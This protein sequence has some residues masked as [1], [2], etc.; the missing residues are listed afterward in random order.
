MNTDLIDPAQDAPQ[1]SAVQATGSDAASAIKAAQALEYASGQVAP[2][3]EPGYEV[4]A[5]GTFGG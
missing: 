4:D 5:A 1:R 2:E 3:T